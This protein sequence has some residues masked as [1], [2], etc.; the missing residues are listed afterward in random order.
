[1]II[2][3]ARANEIC[4]G[5][6]SRYQLSEHY[7]RA[8]LGKAPAAPS[9]LFTPH[10]DVFEAF[11]QTIAVGRA[12]DKIEIAVAELEAEL[13]AKRFDE[14]DREILKLQQEALRL[15]SDHGIKLATAS[16]LA[17]KRE[18]K[19]FVILEPAIKF[20]RDKEFRPEKLGVY[21]YMDGEFDDASYDRAC[22]R[23]KAFLNMY[24]G[25]TAKVA[26]EMFDGLALSAIGSRE[27]SRL[28]ARGVNVASHALGRNRLNSYT[29][30]NG[31][32]INLVRDYASAIESLLASG[33]SR[34]ILA[35][36]IAYEFGGQAKDTAVDRA[37]A[38][39]LDEI[40]VLAD[41]PWSVLNGRFYFHTGVGGERQSIRLIG[42]PDFNF[43]E[44]FQKAVLALF[45]DTK[46]AELIRSRGDHASGN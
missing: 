31:Q 27:L 36:A 38:E 28:E 8:L 17:M 32:G 46:L 14:K 37:I 43:D 34:E 15:A 22:S 40:P 19:K 44:D 33:K 10:H 9:M 12:L 20:V 41:R 23:V 26:N 18:S 24:D 35:T 3:L 1:M 2:D 25:R 13:D 29:M 5:I 39:S 7:Y 4:S 42:K 45:P 30:S 16:L 11:Q 21:I 6:I